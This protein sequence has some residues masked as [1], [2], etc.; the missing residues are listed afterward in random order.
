VSQIPPS[1]F[2]VVLAKIEVVDV[3]KRMIK[4]DRKK[5]NGADWRL[6]EPSGESIIVQARPLKILK[7]EVEEGADA[8]QSYDRVLFVSV[9]KSV[10]Q[11]GAQIQ[12]H[13]SEMANTKLRKMG[14]IPMISQ[15]GTSV[16]TEYLGQ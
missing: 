8:P 14:L 13:V 7:N 9:P 12:V 3:P 2:L 15:T 5:S 10:A 6:A 4:E 1:R 16:D 11:L